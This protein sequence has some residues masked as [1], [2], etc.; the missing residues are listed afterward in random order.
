MGAR[1]SAIVE[2]AIRFVRAGMNKHQA[3]LR[4]GI[5]YSTIHR[6]IGLTGHKKA[7]KNKVLAVEQK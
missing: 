4:C 2:K 5:A 1:R 7:N 3:A 6:V